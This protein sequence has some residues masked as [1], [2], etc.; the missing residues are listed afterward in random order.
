M[1]ALPLT[2]MAAS[3]TLA[4]DP[5]PEP[6]LSGYSLYWGTNSRAYDQIQLV[7]LN[8]VQASATNLVAGTEYFFA[9]TAR[10]WE[11]LESDYSTEVSYQV[12][13]QLTLTAL[14]EEATD[15]A[16]PWA[17]VTNAVTM[18]VPAEPRR[19]YRTKMEVK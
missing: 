8:T 7:E 1:I 19:F 9:V 14:L 2:L 12:P 15:P 10:T 3:V 16:G 17:L 5:S 18:V 6:M 13:E 11:G 4:W